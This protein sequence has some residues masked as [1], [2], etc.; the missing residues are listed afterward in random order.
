MLPGTLRNIL[1]LSPHCDDAVFAC[2]ELME[3][4]PGT[5]VATVFAGH[6]PR[7]LPLTEWDRAGGFSSGDDVMA[8]R[9]EED[10]AAVSLLGA[11]P[12]W[13]DFLDS[14]YRPPHAEEDLYMAM[15]R[16]IEACRPSIVMAPLGLFHSDHRAV[17]LAALGV[18]RQQAAPILF[19]YEDVNYRLIPGL[20]AQRLEEL[21]AEGWAVDEAS[22]PARRSSGRKMAAVHA[23][24][25]QLQALATQGRPG[26]TDAFA[27]ERYWRVR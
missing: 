20:T 22:F 19:L 4:H 14:Q 25:S 7:H 3:A 1:I 5:V 24:V 23:Y 17:H 11:V 12:L 16:L 21:R 6:P 13:L 15:N 18:A 9:R 10:R 27:S 8:V 26:H 2:G